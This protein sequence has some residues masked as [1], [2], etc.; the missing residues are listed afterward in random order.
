M[1][2]LGTSDCKTGKKLWRISWKNN[3]RLTFGLCSWII[4]TTEI[5]QTSKMYGYQQGTHRNNFLQFGIFLLLDKLLHLTSS[6]NI[7]GLFE[8][9]LKWTLIIGDNA[10]TKVVTNFVHNWDQSFTII[11]K[12]VLTKIKVGSKQ[13]FLILFTT[14]GT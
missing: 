14:V 11:F 10:E 6:W 3:R 2:W 5:L 12:S 7:K 13:R 4:K 1:L 9:I 8:G